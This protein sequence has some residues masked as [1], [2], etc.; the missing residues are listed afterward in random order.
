MHSRVCVRQAGCTLRFAVICSIY[1]S[2]LLKQSQNLKKSH[3]KL[4]VLQKCLCY[5]QRLVYCCPVRPV[6]TDAAGLCFV[7]VVIVVVVRIF[8]RCQ[9]TSM[10]VARAH[11]QRRS[12]ALLHHYI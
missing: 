11:N 5:G 9:S 2:L 12:L 1:Y 6:L 8:H 7:G 4:A 3:G 10:D